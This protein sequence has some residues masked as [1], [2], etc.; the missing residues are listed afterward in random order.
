MSIHDIDTI[1]AIRAERLL[2]LHNVIK[3][4]EEKEMKKASSKRK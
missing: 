2:L 3:Q 4:H 1:S